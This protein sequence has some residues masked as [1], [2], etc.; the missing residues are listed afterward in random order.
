MCT[1]E[2]TG[3]SPTFLPTV[4]TDKISGVPGNFLRKSLDLNG[5]ENIESRNLKAEEDFSKMNEESKSSSGKA[6]KYIWSAGHGVVNMKQDYIPSVQ[7]LT[8]E[9]LQ[10]YNI[11]AAPLKDKMLI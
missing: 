11:A 5:L 7:D 4:Y 8:N 2:K 9:L 1:T 6:W 3:P 10:E